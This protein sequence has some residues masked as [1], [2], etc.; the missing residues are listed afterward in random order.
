MLFSHNT[1]TNTCDLQQSLGQL[2]PPQGISVTKEVIY[3][4]GA[5][6]FETGELADI[7]QDI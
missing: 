2:T 1:F 3:H 5:I 6:P 7:T 4:I